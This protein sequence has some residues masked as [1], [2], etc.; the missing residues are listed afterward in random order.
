[1]RKQLE[2]LAKSATDPR[3]R[4]LAND[5]LG[6]KTDLRGA[7][8]GSRYQDVLDDSAR[9]FSGWYQSLTES[10]RVEHERL[11]RLTLDQWQHDAAQESIEKPRTRPSDDD[12]DWEPPTILKRR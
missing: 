2:M 8:L 1:M 9:L 5:V 6:N 4:A 10:D 11:G 3:A 12:D 7:M